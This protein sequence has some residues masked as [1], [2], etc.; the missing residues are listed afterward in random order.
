VHD[1]FDGYVQEEENRRRVQ[2]VLNIQSFPSLR[3]PIL[4]KA[5]MASSWGATAKEELEQIRKDMHL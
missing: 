2:E 5:K 4:W 3:V 1:E